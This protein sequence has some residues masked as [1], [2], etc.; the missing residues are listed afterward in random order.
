V[1]TAVRVPWSSASFLVYLGGFT[2]LAAILAFLGVQSSDHGAGGLVF[3]A[4]IVFA[5]F[6]AS[7]WLARLSA[8]LV[9]AGALAL[10]AV[11]TLV[12][13]LG[14]L[15]EW[16]GWLAD[17]SEP[18]RGFHVSFHFLELAF[19]VAS[20]VALSIYRF[21]PL[22][23][24]VAAGS[25]YFVTDFLSNGGDWTATLTIVI[26]LVLLLVAVAV[27]EGPSKPYA[28]WLH[29][30][31]GIAIGGGLLWFFHDGDFDFILIA[32]AGLAYIALGDRLQRSSWVVL[33]AWGVLQTASHYADKWSDITSAFFPFFLLFPFV[34]FSGFDGQ[35]ERHEHQWLGPFV[36]VV[37]GT[38]FIGI[39]LW[40]ARRRREAM[41]GAELL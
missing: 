38:V 21:P 4:L 41:P 7:A 26:G 32:I 18:W 34:A 28:F 3:W 39:A 1:V 29:V 37:A 6:T 40:L 23:F 35:E 27:D 30:G 24:F 19:L 12:V 36:F 15:L 17:F 14:G 13:F 16:F 8:H 2:I 22:V 9:T 33:G 11:T 10:S 5:V 25:W 20:A 31:A